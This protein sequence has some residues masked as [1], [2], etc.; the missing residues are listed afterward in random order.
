MYIDV[1]LTSVLAGVPTVQQNK[2]ADEIQKILSDV[3]YTHQNDNLLRPSVVEE[4]SLAESLKVLLSLKQSWP[5]PAYDSY[6][7]GTQKI[8]KKKSAQRKHQQSRSKRPSAV[9]PES[10][11][12]EAEEWPPRRSRGQPPLTPFE[13]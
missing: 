9:K 11:E 8:Q 3:K 2:E 4:A 10:D 5:V 7:L 6:I 12:K 1:I 13:K